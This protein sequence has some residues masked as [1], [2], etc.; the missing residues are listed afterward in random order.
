MRTTALLGSFRI[1]H[2]NILW[3]DVPVDKSA[4]GL[5]S[6]SVED[7]ESLEDAVREFDRSSGRKTTSRSIENIPQRL[8][9][10]EAGDDIRTTD[11]DRFGH[12]GVPPVG[13]GGAQE[14]VLI[15]RRGGVRR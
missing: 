1:S 6:G 2:H 10:N 12:T 11:L 5:F 14:V 15:L 7:I 8:P 4:Q 9:L 3:L 13:D